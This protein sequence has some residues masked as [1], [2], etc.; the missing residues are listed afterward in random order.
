NKLDPDYFVIQNLP[1]NILFFQEMY[2]HLKDKKLVSPSNINKIMK[3]DP[4]LNGHGAKA[5]SFL[6]NQNIAGKFKKYLDLIPNLY[7]NCNQF[8]FVGKKDCFIQIRDNKILDKF[9]L[10]EDFNNF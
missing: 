8:T 9:K 4:S 10:A 6:S 7:G 2:N 1:I 3:V 5:L